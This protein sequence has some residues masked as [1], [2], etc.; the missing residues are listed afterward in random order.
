MRLHVKRLFV[1][2]VLIQTIVV[3]GFWYTHWIPKHDIILIQS[4]INGQRLRDNTL[5]HS[6]HQ[7]AADYKRL[8]ET[9]YRPRYNVSLEIF[10]KKCG[11]I[12]VPLPLAVGDTWYPVD[13]TSSTYVFSAYF[14]NK[15]KEVSIVGIK[16]ARQG[17]GVTSQMW[18]ENGDKLML[19]ESTCKTQD[20]SESHGRK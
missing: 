13:T 2:C 5:I 6:F 11:N 17:P 3:F 15:S 14:C 1:V 12:T 20:L 10:D 19:T 16:A 4:F 18:Y 8:V 9:T 7:K